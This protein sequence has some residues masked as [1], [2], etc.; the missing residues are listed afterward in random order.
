M[1][2]M[3]D[4][5]DNF[6]T[7]FLDGNTKVNL[8]ALSQ[9]NIQLIGLILIM[10]NCVY[11]IRGH[12]SLFRDCLSLKVTGSAPTILSNCMHED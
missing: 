8:I 10:I 12:I 11:F 4:S 1:L 3:N 5:L 7:H 9:R 6:C 2:V